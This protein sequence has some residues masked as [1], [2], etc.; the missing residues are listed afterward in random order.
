M[1]LIISREYEHF[2]VA[3]N[4][5]KDRGPVITFLPIPH[6][7]GIAYDPAYGLLHVASTRNPN[8]LVDLRPVQDADSTVSSPLLPTR[9]QFLPGRL[10][11]HDL[12]IVGGQLYGNAVGLNAVVRLAAGRA[13]PSWWPRCIDTPTGPAFEANYLQ[14]NSIAAGS[15]LEDCFFT[16]SADRRSRRRPGH[17]DFPVDGRGV[18]FSGASREVVARGLTRPHS[19]RLHRTRVWLDNSGYGELGFVED[20][21]FSTALRLPGWTRG[22]CFVGSIAFVGTSRVLSRFTQYAPGLNPA[23]CVCAI[24]A[25]DLASGTVLGSLTWPAG[26]QIFAIEPIPGEF[27][28]G[29]PFVAGRRAAKREK[30]LFFAFDD[31]A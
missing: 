24:H 1:T 22:L 21:R 30:R 2:L 11:L 13:E 29:L 6:P 7:S 3:I 26:N 4:Q 14:L 15:T 31:V 9:S 12:A 10:Y 17:K 18:V 5:P 27:S 28:E 19:A 23:T 25:V 16:A 20:G 8:Q